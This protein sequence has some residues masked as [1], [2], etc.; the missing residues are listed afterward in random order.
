MRL[1]NLKKE[2][3]TREEY[4]ED[5]QKFIYSDPYGFEN[6][7]EFLL[8]MQGAPMNELPDDFKSWLLA[9]MNPDEE[10]TLPCYGIY[11]EAE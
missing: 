8:Y 9:Y 2:G 10:Q 11:N 4:Y 6:A 1:E 3:T 7:G 5:N